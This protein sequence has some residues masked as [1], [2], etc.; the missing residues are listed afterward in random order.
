MEQTMKR[1]L[2][3][4]FLLASCLFQGDTVLAQAEIKMVR[5]A[6]LKDAQE[7]FVAIKGEFQIF[8]ASLKE[9]PT[10][11]KLWWGKNVKATEKGFQLGSQEF[12][13]SPIRIVPKKDATIY[14]NNRR[15]RGEMD[16]FQNAQRR[17]LVVNAV[18][19]ENYIKG[20][21]Y[22]EVS[23]YWPME[24]LKA[25]AVAARSYALYQMQM[26]RHKDFDVTSDIYSQVYGG[27]GSERYRTNIAIERTKG[28]GMG[29]RGKLLLAYFHGTCAGQS[30]EVSELWREGVPALKGVA[31][32]FC[33]F[34]PHFFW[35]KNFRLKDIQDKL[36][37]KGYGLGLIKEI[38]IIER[39]TSGRIKTL[40]IETRDGKK[41]NISGKDFREIIGP[42]NIKSNNYEVDMQGYYMDLIGKGWGHGVGMCQWGAAQMAS[43]GYSYEQILK[44]YY[45]GVDIV[46]Y[47]TGKF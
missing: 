7:F 41:A 20:V 11:Q 37:A 24:S 30:E 10:Q 15:F 23:H 26:N 34:S 35:K 14:I 3:A 45:P 12:L 19:L 43:E 27:R 8:D 18:E 29:Y 5:V 33:R 22:H 6:I 42:N 17:L 38:R 31:C 9:I 21:L 39:N 13:T 47:E 40:E 16:I 36:N 4:I 28:L 2:Y 25:Q 32:S 1:F 46:S 44:Y